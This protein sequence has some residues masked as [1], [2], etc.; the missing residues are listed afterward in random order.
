MASHCRYSTLLSLRLGCAAGVIGG[1]AGCGNDQLNPLANEPLATEE[2]PAPDIFAEPATFEFSA[3]E[4]DGFATKLFQIG[5][6]GDSLLQVGAVE[7]TGPGAGMFSITQ[8]RVSGQSLAP[9]SLSTIEVT[10]AP[11]GVAFYDATLEVE[12]NDPD[13]NPLRIELRAQGIVTGGPIAVCAVTPATIHLASQTATFSGSASYDPHGYGLISYAWRL[14][15]K[16]TGSAAA[17]PT[18][19][20][21]SDCGPFT[22]DVAGIYTGELTVEN[23]F[24]MSSSCTV[25]LQVAWQGPH[26]VCS[27]TPGTVHP[28][29]ETA[30][31]KGSGSSDPGGNAITS[32]AWRLVSQPNGSAVNMPSCSN[33]P[34]C[35]PFAPDLAGTYVGELTVTN[36]V[37][38]TGI[39]TATLTAVP[40]E[41]LWIE[42]YW[43]HSG[44]DMDLHLLAPGGT[45]RTSSDCY[46]MNCVGGG[47]DWG[48]IG[49][50]ADDPALDLDDI[51]GT[52]P[53]NINIT[54]PAAGE[55]KVF[56]NDYPES[57]YTSAN[58]VTVKVYIAG[59]QVFTDTRSISGEGSDTYFCKIAWPSGVVTRL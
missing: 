53:E 37:G 49:N 33:T 30:T 25:D 57:S 2:A 7:L 24:G 26:A 55:Y 38:L 23:E 43:T 45:P 41:N 44:D 46:F 22:P 19:L 18:C 40:L 21:T 17:M 20:G 16:P 36:S 27:V 3:V 42:M 12:S 35:G 32:Y 1:S 50:D 10:F 5:N 4:V 58:A 8:D 59:N 29:F 13:E 6:S 31:W 51:P 28:P 9:N 39:C 48:V 54:A 47:P 11:E 56:V 14:I 34:D 15:D 52:G